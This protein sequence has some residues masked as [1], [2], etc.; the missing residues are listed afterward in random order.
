MQSTTKSAAATATPFYIIANNNQTQ[1][2][3]DRF[4]AKLMLE[5]DPQKIWPVGVGSNID[6]WFQYLDN[7]KSQVHRKD[8]AVSALVEIFL[9]LC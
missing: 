2:V 4:T 7:N 1:A 9:K 8:P 5:T 3:I 6:F